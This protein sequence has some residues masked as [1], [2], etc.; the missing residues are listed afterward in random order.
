VFDVLV[1]YES[2]RMLLGGRQ[3]LD[4]NSTESPKL[5]LPNALERQ[6]G[7]KLETTT[8]DVPVI[9]IDAAEKPTPD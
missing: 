5:P 4:P 8:G 2:Q 9:V 7:L 6:L 3:G 1:E